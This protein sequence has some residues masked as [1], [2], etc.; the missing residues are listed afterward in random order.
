MDFIKYPTR[1]FLSTLAHADQTIYLHLLFRHFHFCS[2]DYNR[3]FYFSNR[4][5]AKIA[6]C[7]LDTIWKSKKR[8]R[9]S[10]LIV[11]WRGDKNRTYYKIISDN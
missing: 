10:G 1:A 7:S 8:L 2:N 3:S 9:D 4:D 6:G 11:F 5:L